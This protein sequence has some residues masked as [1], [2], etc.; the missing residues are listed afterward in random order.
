MARDKELVPDPSFQSR[1]CQGLRALG[2]RDE[3]GVLN[4]FSRARNEPRRSRAPRRQPVSDL[5]VEYF[6]GRS[7]GRSRRFRRT[8]F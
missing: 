8:G 7:V 4:G 1:R 5:N 2:P 3:I 6:I